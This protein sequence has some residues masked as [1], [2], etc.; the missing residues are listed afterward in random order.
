MCAAAPAFSQSASPAAKPA[1]S[2]TPS[3]STGPPAKKEAPRRP[4]LSILRPGAAPLA[5][6]QYRGKILALIFIS[7]ECSHCQ[8]FTKAIV[9]IA[10]TYSARG[11]QFVE[12]AVNDGAEN[13]IKEFVERFQPSFPVGW[14]TQESMMSFLGASFMDPHAMYVPHMVLLDRAGYVRGDFEPGEPFYSNPAANV[15]AALDKLLK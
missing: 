10:K 11:V 1:A 7:T 6:S 14:G 15:P 2:K 4:A 8:D 3:S 12:C 13:R 9:P 5:I